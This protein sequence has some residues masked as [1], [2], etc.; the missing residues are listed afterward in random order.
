VLPCNPSPSSNK[1]LHIVHKTSHAAAS[2][3]WPVVS[4]WWPDLGKVFTA[5]FIELQCTSLATR[6][7]LAH[8]G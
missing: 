2:V 8:S 4:L 5:S 1:T 3:A 7:G 6:G